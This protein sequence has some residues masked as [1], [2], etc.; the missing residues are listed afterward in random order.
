MNIRERLQAFWTGERPD[1]IPYTIYEWEW[2]HAA[3][4]PGWLPLFDLGL[5]VTW[6]LPTVKTTTPDV[7]HRTD[8]WREGGKQ[9]E[10]HTIHTPVG[11]LYETH[12]DGWH[13]KYLLETADDYRVMTYIVR[14]TVIEPD[15]STFLEQE[16]ALPSFGVALVDARRTPIQT[17]LVDYAGAEN[18]GYHLFDLEA[19]VMELYDAL[20]TNFRRIIELVAAG[21]GQLVYL[22]ENFSADMIGPTRYKSMI[23]PVYEECFPLLHSAGKIISTHYDGRLSAVKE[24]IAG[25]PMDILES[26]TAPPEGDMTLAQARAAWP[27]KRFWSNLNI[28]CYDLPPDALRQE[29]W[30]RVQ[31]AAP[32][33]RGLA[34]EVS[35]QLP[36]N[37]KES[38]AT[39]LK[40]LRDL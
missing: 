5:G 16:C 34:F 24:T 10:R 3:S 38:M 6:H 8:T 33:G 25:A 21:P 7:E 1:I 27:E 28:S 22:L 37:W 39:V 9:I 31:Q 11:D 35:E 19:E 4:D 15:Y 26:L 23:L 18:F 36:H 12:V 40:A 14:N 32:E 29:I 17:I 30:E 2:R 13:D 20:L